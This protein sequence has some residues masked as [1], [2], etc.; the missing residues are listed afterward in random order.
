MENHVL[1]GT[2]G[3]R[4]DIL[5]YWSSPHTGIVYPA[6]WRLTCG[7]EQYIVTP[8]VAD[9]ELQH[10]W[11][12]PKHWEGASSVA[13]ED[14]RAMGLAYVELAGYKRSENVPR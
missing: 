14:G 8:L 7:A 11:Q 4:V 3:Y 2:E 1:R 13:T 9:Q 5:D 12:S 6:K 10:P